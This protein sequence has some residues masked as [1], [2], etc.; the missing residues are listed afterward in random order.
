VN[1]GFNG[2]LLCI[3]KYLTAL[4]QTSIIR[5]MASIH[6]LQPPLPESSDLHDRAVENLR[7]IRETMEAA[8]SFTA[9]SGW[10]QVIVGVTALITA[11][12]ASTLS[13]PDAWLA[14]WLGE[15][16]LAIA[17]AT[18]TT[19]YKAR[20]AGMPLFSVPARKFVLSFSP[21][22]IAGAV[23]T[24][25]LYQAGATAMIQGMWLLLFG[26]GIVTGGAFSVKIVPVMGLCFMLLGSI[27]L[28][29]PASWN[30]WF[31][32][33]GFGLLHIIFGVLIARRHGG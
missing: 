21:P 22:L 26:T 1:K 9:V 6:R 11:G 32:A 25:V 27:A 8:T 31:M 28:L 29:S 13:Q 12:I 10:G 24:L 4:Q 16:L 7:F 30:P 19:V 33:A 15:A 5:S 18:A 20:A 14:L 3:V 23:L 17:I 2:I